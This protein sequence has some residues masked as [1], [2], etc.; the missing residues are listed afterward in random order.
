M[1][2]S[3]F[4]TLALLVVMLHIQRKIMS[5]VSEMNAAV[6]ASFAQ[7]NTAIEG[8]KGDVASLNDKI[9]ALQNSSGELSPEDQAAL[10]E[11]QSTAQ[12]MADK[13]TALD[14][15]TPPV[16]SEGAEDNTSGGV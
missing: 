10:D 4:L 7:M 2:L 3:A 9:T 14:S 11:I 6:K 12:A 16:A 8:V 1:T 15:L 5:K 13:L